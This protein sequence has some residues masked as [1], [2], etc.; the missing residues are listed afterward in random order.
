MIQVNRVS[1]HYG[2]IKAVNRISF[3]AKLGSTTVLVGTSGSGKTTTL[4]TINRLIEPSEG[5]ILIDGKDI[6][7]QKPQLLR[8]QIGYVS[9]N[10]G[11]FPHY[12]VRQ[13]V[14]IVPSLIGWSAEKTLQRSEEILEQLLIPMAQFGHKFPKELSGGQY[15][16]VALARAL[17]TR[18]PVLLMDEP[19]GALDPV[20]RQQIRQE[21]KSLP[22]HPERSIV[23]VTHD[24]AEAIELGDQ[25][26]V[27][28]RG[29]CLQQG[30]ASDLLFKPRDSFIKSF[31]DTQRF[32]LELSAVT[33]EQAIH[34]LHSNQHSTSTKIETR[35]LTLWE[36]ITLME[37]ENLTSL[38]YQSSS[39]QIFQLTIPILLSCISQIKAKY[40]IT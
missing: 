12:T 32:Q 37:K 15:Q 8:R 10:N 28:D 11:L 35:N 4:K 6:S 16:R 31:F 36:T 19:F 22:G 33:L 27:M 21:L 14:A 25:I 40:G 5:Q 20:T 39:G 2:S 24:L 26:V 34:Y 38:Y 9:Q 17:V 3:E 7:L 18:P 13:N 29:K 1:K 30:P 23:L